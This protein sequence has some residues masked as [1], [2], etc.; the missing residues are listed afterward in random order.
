MPGSS[1]D[2]YKSR[3]L[4]CLS[5]GKLFWAP[6]AMTC[7]CLFRLFL[8]LVPAAFLQGKRLGPTSP[9]RYSRFL[10]PSRA[11][12]LRWDFD[13]EAEI[14]TF[15]LQVQT[16]GWI[17][18]GITDRYTFVGSDL[19]VGG[20]LPNGNVYFSVSLR[21]SN[22]CWV[23]DGFISIVSNLQP[24]EELLPWVEDSFPSRKELFFCKHSQA[25]QTLVD[26]R[27]LPTKMF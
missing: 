26:C 5:A 7:A 16:T 21:I 23:E 3:P 4:E 2:T 22:L 12:F 10:D 9:L 20:V 6:E 11:V 19:V 14:I 27:F 17:G 13:Y 15:E 18:L 8:L 24:T 25:Q 1:I